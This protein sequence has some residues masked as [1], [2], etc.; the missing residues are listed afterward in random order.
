[1][2]RKLVSLRSSFKQSKIVEQGSGWYLVDE[3]YPSSTES[4]SASLNVLIR[5]TDGYLRRVSNKRKRQVA[6]ADER[7]IEEIV[8]EVLD[9]IVEIIG[10][11][12]Y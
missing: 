1:M 3:E 8:K 5:R 6:N 2:A 12:L 10:E 4:E 9:E 11:T 7:K